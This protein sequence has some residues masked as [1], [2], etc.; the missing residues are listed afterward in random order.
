MY[1]GV[2]AK[3]YLTYMRHVRFFSFWSFI[4]FGEIHDSRM[5]LWDVGCASLC[6]GL[7]VGEVPLAVRE[8]GDE[9]PICA[10]CISGLLPIVQTTE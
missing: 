4:C 8:Y 3:G 6:W 7:V 9:L 10:V 1:V 5:R 2:F